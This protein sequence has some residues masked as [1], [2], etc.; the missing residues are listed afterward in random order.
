MT[1]GSE[2]RVITKEEPQLYVDLCNYDGIATVVETR[3]NV[4]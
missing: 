4:A 3:Q 1:C 2:A